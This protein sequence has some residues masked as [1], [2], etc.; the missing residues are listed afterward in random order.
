[1]DDHY[2][3]RPSHTNEEPKLVSSRTPHLRIH[4]GSD[5]TDDSP[6]SQSPPSMS[7]H[8]RHTHHMRVC[9]KRVSTGTERTI[10]IHTLSPAETHT[11]TK[12]THTTS[13]HRYRITRT[14]TRFCSMTSCKPCLVCVRIQI[15]LNSKVFL[16]FLTKKTPPP[17]RNPTTEE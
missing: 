6:L 16:P 8:T 5:L 1:M 3:C 2:E 10:R 14:S 17:H 12:T 7:C 4:T 13:D 9:P 11:E 15:S